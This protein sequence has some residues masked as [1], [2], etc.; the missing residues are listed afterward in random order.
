[1]NFKF[2]P[3]P[4]NEKN[5][6]RK[7]GFEFEFAGLDFHITSQII[8]NI[9][10]GE[11]KEI[12]RYQQRVV[13]TSFGDFKLEFDS[14]FLKEKRYENF[15]KEIGINLNEYSFHNK[16]EDI[17]ASVSSNLVPFEVILPPI[18]IDQL[19]KVEEFREELHR[20]NAEGTKAS[21]LY[22]FALHINPE[23]PDLETKTITNYLKAFLLLQYWIFEESKVS[24]TR[25]R[26]TTY[27]NYFPEEYLLMVLNQ[28][29]QPDIDKLISH[30][31]KYNPTRNRPLDVYPLF[32]Y[33][34]GQEVK[35]GVDDP[36]L[37]NP[38]PTFHYRLPDCKIDDPQWTLDKEWNAWIQVEELAEDPDKMDLMMKDFQKLHN[39]HFLNLKKKWSKKV[40]KYLN[41]K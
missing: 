23:L 18:P 3:R 6:Y 24:F 19:N 33:L 12:D 25:H 32:T 37:I 15:L 22:A 13:N 28:N 35:V 38:R 17:V 26:L 29:Y 40:K 14:R 11:V 16:L 41:E 8:I 7:A 30:Y 1:M 9:F 39:E 10:G 21:P 31:K 36:D 34:K 5:E 4:Y 20:H 27:I 2:P